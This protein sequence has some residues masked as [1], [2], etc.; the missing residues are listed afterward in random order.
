MKKAIIKTAAFLLILA[1]LFAAFAGVYSFKFGDGI[2][3]LKTFYRQPKDSIDVVFVGS[4]HIYENVS[5][6]VLW[7]EYGIAAYDLAGSMQPVWNS[8]Y[9]IN[10]CLKTQH[11][12]LIVMDINSAVLSD[13]SNSGAKD[14]TDMSRIIKNT[15]GMKPSRDKL[16]AIKASA[17][18]SFWREYILEFPTYHTRY[19]ELS[20]ADY[21]PYNNI[22]YFEYWKGFGMNATV[23]PQ[24]SPP[25]SRRTRWASSRKSQRIISQKYSGCARKRACRCC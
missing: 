8:Y 13:N 15:Y 19:S 25:A 22:A 17:N 24:E 18:S 5:T 1:A 14:L 3:G 20:K 4:S 2:Y 9:Y 21:L 7:D 23:V 11:P 12:K 16:E 10:E 6:G